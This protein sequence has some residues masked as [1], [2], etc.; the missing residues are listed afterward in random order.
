MEIE[1]SA[2]QKVMALEEVLLTLP[3]EQVFVFNEYCEG[4]Y[5]RS[6]VLKKDTIL[7]G[8]IHS[9]ECFFVLRSGVLLLSSGEKSGVIYAGEMYKSEIGIK[10]AGVALTDC[11]FTTI[12][13]NPMNI[14]NENELIRYYTVENILQLGC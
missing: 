8:R 13:A 11:V 4:L 1:K 14:V 12:H 2:L 5:A 3:Q 10:R 6:V 7:T 9:K